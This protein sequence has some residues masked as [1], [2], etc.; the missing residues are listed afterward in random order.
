MAAC[1]RDPGVDERL[2]AAEAVG[3]CK[4]SFVVEPVL[5]LT[6]LLTVRCFLGVCTGGL[7]VLLVEADVDFFILVCRWCDYDEL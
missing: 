4:C 2:P 7:E 6:L 3:A 5:L 1:P